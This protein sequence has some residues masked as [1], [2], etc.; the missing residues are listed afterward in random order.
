MGNRPLLVAVDVQ[1][2]YRDFAPWALGDVEA[3]ANTI[4]GLAEALRCPLLC[5]RTVLPS[6]HGVVTGP[7][8]T[9]EERWQPLA[10]RVA[11]EPGLLDPLPGLR[12]RCARVFDKHTYSAFEDPAFDAHVRAYRPSPLL[13]A[14]VEADICVLATV[15][16]ACDRNHPVWVITDA[17]SGPDALAHRGALATLARMPEQV[18]LV[19]AREAERALAPERS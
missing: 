8:H 15:F 16:G 10:V 19:S 4:V 7:W 9:Y 5:T 1:Q 14:G 3:V 2:L 18:R 12:R 17:L 6:A 13:I 11:S